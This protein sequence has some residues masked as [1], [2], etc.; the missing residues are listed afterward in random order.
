MR[1][2]KLEIDANPE[3]TI[4]ISI[5]ISAIPVPK[6]CHIDWFRVFV[7]LDRAG[8][9]LKKIEE[10]TGIKANKMKGWRLYGHAA[11]LEDGL[12][13]IRIWK[14]VTGKPIELLPIENEYGR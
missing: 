5:M 2:L 10:K 14:E 4:G 11:R 1:Q 7:D 3:F 8:M 6:D 13:V 9:N 12:A